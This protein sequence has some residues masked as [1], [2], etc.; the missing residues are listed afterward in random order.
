M[1]HM[2]SS[3]GNTML[4]TLRSGWEKEPN[5]LVPIIMLKGSLNQVWNDAVS[6]FCRIFYNMRAA[7]VDAVFLNGMT[8]INSTQLS[9]TQCILQGKYS[10]I[11]SLGL[12]HWTNGNWK[13]IWENSACSFLLEIFCA[14][15]SIT[16]WNKNIFLG[17]GTRECFFFF[18]RIRISF[19]IIPS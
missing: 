19:F 9:L 2:Q 15:M 1:P 18:C 17:E 8:K 3:A 6:I 13:L 12:K 16:V 4:H 5:D 7:I 11:E 10:I 14:F